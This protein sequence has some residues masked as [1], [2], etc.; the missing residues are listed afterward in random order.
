MNSIE[1]IIGVVI[2]SMMVWVIVNVIRKSSL[3]RIDLMILCVL[4]IVMR[5]V[6]LEGV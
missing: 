5:S 6:V 4:F 2:D 3:G 1:R